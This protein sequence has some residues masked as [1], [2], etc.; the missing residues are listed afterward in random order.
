MG[1]F[2]TLFRRREGGVAS[3]DI[4]KE[5]LQLVLVHDRIRVSPELLEVLKGDLIAAISKHIE[6]DREGMEVSVQRSENSARI[7]ADIPVRRIR[8]E[9]Q[10]PLTNR[11]WSRTR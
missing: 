6:I 3:K 11:G 4:A 5:R 9:S 1:F 10:V 2:D 8:N 7:V